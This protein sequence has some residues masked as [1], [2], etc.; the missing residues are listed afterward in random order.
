MMRFLSSYYISMRYILIAL[1]VFASASSV[2]AGCDGDCDG[3]VS[4]PGG[5]AM[6]GGAYYSYYSIPLDEFYSMNALLALLH[7][8][9]NNPR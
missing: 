8:M 6:F 7:S 2:F 4:G 9:Q 5:G 1:M 3:P